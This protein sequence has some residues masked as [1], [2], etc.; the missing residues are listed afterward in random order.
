[1]PRKVIEVKSE[2]ISEAKVLM[3]KAGDE[4]G[5]FQ[6]RTLDYL[7]KF[8]K[9]EKARETVENLV[10]KLGLNIGDA[11]QLV[12]CMPNSIQEVRSILTVKGKV[13]LTEELDKILKELD[14]FRS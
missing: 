1:M 3:E 13:I 6:R 2:T 10:K 8:A 7:N 14:K 11:I 9:N 5:E 12:N 4:L